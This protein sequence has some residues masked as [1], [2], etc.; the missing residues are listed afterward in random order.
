[1][2][3]IPLG[4]LDRGTGKGN[5][6]LLHR[7]A[8]AQ[9]TDCI[10]DLENIDGN[11]TSYK[12]DD[13]NNQVIFNGAS[14]DERNK[15]K[16]FGSNVLTPSDDTYT[17]TPVDKHKNINTTELRDVYLGADGLWHS[18]HETTILT[19]VDDWNEWLVD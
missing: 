6:H 15:I 16:N 11:Y 4:V 10:V 17:L 1:M 18:I 19:I 12:N 14:K 2:N 3:Y 8:G 7:D 5:L 13:M 9:F